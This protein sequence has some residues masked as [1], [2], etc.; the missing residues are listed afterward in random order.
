MPKGYIIARIDV[1]DDARY[2]EYA[3]AATPAIRRY[4]GTV[5]VRGGTARTLEGEGR[6]RNVVIEFASL[7]AATDYYDSPEYE[8]AR[9]LRSG[10]AVAD[11][12]AV[13]GA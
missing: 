9:S 4:G 7:Q 2:A 5:L 1:L 12:V 6:T 13:E 8:A 11:F 3:A 10:I